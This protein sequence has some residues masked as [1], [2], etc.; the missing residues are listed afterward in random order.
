MDTNFL[1]VFK[2]VHGKIF[3][4]WL[5][6]ETMSHAVGVVEVSDHVGYVEISSAEKPA[7]RK[8]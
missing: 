1:R 7:S 5:H 6:A 2:A 8:A 3:S 4:V